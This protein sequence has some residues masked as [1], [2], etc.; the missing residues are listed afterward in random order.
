MPTCNEIIHILNQVIDDV[1]INRKFTFDFYK[2]LSSENI[3]KKDIEEFNSS[4]FISTIKFQ[5]EEFSDFLKGGDQ[6]L[7][8]AYPDYTKPEVRKMRE[9]LEGLLE[10]GKRYEQA[11][12]KRRPYKKRKTA[13]K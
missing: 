1:I 2:Y 10:N 6:F 7:R 12:K 8:E 11:K 9:Y 5:I 4:S 3:S 13:T